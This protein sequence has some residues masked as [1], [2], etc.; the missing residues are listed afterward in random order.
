MDVMRGVERAA[1]HPVLRPAL[2]AVAHVLGA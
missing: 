2:D 1:R